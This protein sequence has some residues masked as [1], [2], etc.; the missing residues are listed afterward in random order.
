MAK[1]RKGINE[2]LAN[3]GGAY[4]TKNIPFFIFL[5]LLGLVYISN[6]HLAMKRVRKINKMTEVVKQKRWY[7]IQGLSEAMQKKKLSSIKKDVKS[8]GLEEILS[9]PQII[10]KQ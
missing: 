7:Y 2:V 3:Q 4:V 1:R 9:P 5:A 8:I 10:V 6:S